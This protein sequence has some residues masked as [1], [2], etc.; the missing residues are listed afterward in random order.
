MLR[1]HHLAAGVLKPAPPPALATLDTLL[2]PAAPP[3]IA[4]AVDAAEVHRDTIGGRFTTED[5]RRYCLRTD[6]TALFRKDAPF[7]PR[8]SS[9]SHAVMLESINYPGRFLH[10]RDFQLRLDPYDNSGPYRADSSF[11]LVGAWV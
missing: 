4:A 6:G 2:R 5:L 11:R 9:Y 7:C 1:L 10:H 3:S 8:P